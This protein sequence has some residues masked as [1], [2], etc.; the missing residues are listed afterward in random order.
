M[1]TKETKDQTCWFLKIH[2]QYTQ[3]NTA[4]LTLLKNSINLHEYSFV[5]TPLNI[6]HHYIFL[7]NQNSGGGW[8]TLMH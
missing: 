4:S 2:F 8:S 7:D 1:K 6:I 3:K 5:Q